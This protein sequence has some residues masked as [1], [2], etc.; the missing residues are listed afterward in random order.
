MARRSG[1]EASHTLRRDDDGDLTHLTA[2]RRRLAIHDGRRPREALDHRRA[3]HD[4]GRRARQHRST[5]A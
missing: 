3:Q 2:R 4:P 1:A 5:T